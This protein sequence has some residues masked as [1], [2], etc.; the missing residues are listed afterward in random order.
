MTPIIISPSDN[1]ETINIRWDDYPFIKSQ[2]IS[3]LKAQGW[4]QSEID[5]FFSPGAEVEM[6]LIYHKDNG[7]FMVEAD[8]VA[9]LSELHSPYSGEIFSTED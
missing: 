5:N 2:K 3:E 8:S 1:P 4:T 9:D 7:L 6:E